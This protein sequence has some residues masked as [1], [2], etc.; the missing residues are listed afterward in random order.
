[1]AMKQTSLATAL[2]RIEAAL[3]RAEA[4]APDALAWQKRHA[5]LKISVQDAIDDLDNLMTQRKP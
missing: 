3:S 2:D 4:A 5:R 1:M